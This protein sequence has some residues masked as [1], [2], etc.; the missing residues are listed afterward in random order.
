MVIIPWLLVIKAKSQIPG[1]HGTACEMNGYDS[2]THATGI[3][4]GH[5]NKTGLD[6]S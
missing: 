5:R 1:N 3:S 6:E 4:L 2:I